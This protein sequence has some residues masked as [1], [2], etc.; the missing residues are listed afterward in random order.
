MRI[1][2][3]KF[4]YFIISVARSIDQLCQQQANIITLFQFNSRILVKDFVV[5]ICYSCM[6]LVFHEF[7]E[8]KFRARLCIN[9]TEIQYMLKYML[10]YIVREREVIA[11]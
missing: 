10:N 8:M 2:V 11:I 9:G 3:L 6:F 7:N 4:G 5:G 1:C